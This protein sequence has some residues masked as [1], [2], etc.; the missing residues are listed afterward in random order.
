MWKALVYKELRET[1]G[2]A[3]LALLAYL[4]LLYNLIAL[5]VKLG[6]IASSEIPFVGVGLEGVF[7]FI[8]VLLA[9]AVGLKQTIGESLG[10]TW[11][12]LFHRPVERWKL[13]ALKLAVGMTVVLSLMALPILV[14]AHW[15]ATPGTH[16][17]PFE[18]SMTRNAWQGWLAMTPIYL[19]AFLVGL[20]P[21]RW[22]GSRLL[23]LA[24]TALVTVMIQG[25]PWWWPA[26]A[27]AILLLDA[28]LAAAIFY[29]AKTRDFG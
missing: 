14:Y 2:L 25:F 15:A 16:A 11:L 13:V 3:A 20:R 17:S 18:W 28:W 19:A 4:F 12:F 24:G 9:T 1:R 8:S 22:F 6:T 10:N 23:P 29:V 26:G 5:A 7:I 27:L 21:G